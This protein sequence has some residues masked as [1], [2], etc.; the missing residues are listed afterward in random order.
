[1]L[2]TTPQRDAARRD[3][4]PRQWERL[5]YRA[6]PFVEPI[7]ARYGMRVYDV[8][9]EWTTYRSE[10]I[11]RGQSATERGFERMMHGKSGVSQ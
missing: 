10:C 2:R 11:R 8:W 6:M 1:M 7:A 5:K 4:I 9:C 3:S